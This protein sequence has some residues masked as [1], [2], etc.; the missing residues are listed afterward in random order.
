MDLAQI[1]G[2]KPTMRPGE[3]AIVTYEQ[4]GQNPL[5]AVWIE[6]RAAFGAASP[7]TTD[8]TVPT[9]GYERIHGFVESVGV[10]TMT[11]KA[12]DGRTMTVD[13]R[14]SRGQTNDV[15]PGDLVHVV[16]RATADRFVAEAIQRD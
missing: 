9:S 8:P 1:V 5:A 15:R 11:L 4:V 7:R 3:T 6:T 10:G 2:P 14:N 16:G 12:D 13:I